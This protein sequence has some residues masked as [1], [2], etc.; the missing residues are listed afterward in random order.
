MILSMSYEYLIGN[1]L[2]YSAKRSEPW[3]GVGGSYTGRRRLLAVHIAAWSNL[4][5]CPIRP[6]K[7]RK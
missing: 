2:K 6:T 1:A 5:I 7:L 4:M 3:S